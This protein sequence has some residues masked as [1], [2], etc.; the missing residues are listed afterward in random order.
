[1]KLWMKNS[2][3]KVLSKLQTVAKRQIQIRAHLLQGMWG[4]EVA[5]LKT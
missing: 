4:K 3:I 5:Y 2:I 1:M